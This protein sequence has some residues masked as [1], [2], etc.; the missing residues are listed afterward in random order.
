MKP[1]HVLSS[2]IVFFVIMP[3]IGYG[4]LPTDVQPV[5]FVLCVAAI[6]LLVY[7]RAL[8]IPKPALLCIAVLFLSVVGFFAGTAF[9]ERD[10]F[11]DARAIFGHLSSIVILVVFASCLVLLPATRVAGIA[12]AT[13]ALIYVGFV[14]NILDLTEWI[15]VVVARAEFEWF[16]DQARGLTSFFPE[17]SRLANQMVLYLVL[18][19][20]I[21]RMNSTRLCLVLAIGALSGS[22]QFF[23]N[24]FVLVLST[25]VAAV[26]TR[27]Q[28]T[29]NRFAVVLVLAVSAGFALVIR[30]YADDLVEL[31]FPIRGIYAMRELLIFNLTALGQDNGFLFKISGLAQGLAA[32]YASPFSLELG[33]ALYFENDHAA[34]AA[35]EGLLTALFDAG[36]FPL[37]ER[38]YSVFGAWVTDLKLPGLV[39]S[40]LFAVSLHRQ[41]SRAAGFSG[42]VATAF[43]LTTVFLFLLRS[44]TSDPTFWATVAALAMS[45]ALS[46]R[47]V[48]EEMAGD[49]GAL[50]HE[51]ISSTTGPVVAPSVGGSSG[52]A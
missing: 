31:G 7:H 46:A 27:G 8:H 11:F 26:M 29:G 52:V 22:G 16:D 14:L 20:A 13:L 17:Q 33:A 48:A 39:L 47:R 42:A 12:D 43:F 3:Y 37:P 23:I 6:P 9:A 25:I 35:Y 21:G 30:D 49:N 2:L 15:Q 19:W 32:A 40:I 24:T 34:L 41:L 38:S 5:A 10:L 45:G 51:D 44:N 18:Y 28:S 4:G 50:H 1:L 36:R